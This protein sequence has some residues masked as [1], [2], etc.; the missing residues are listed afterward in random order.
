MALPFLNMQ[1][2][3]VKKKGKICSPRPWRIGQEVG[4]NLS[5]DSL[6]YT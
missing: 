4:L 6:V 2:A 5:T 3:F 1:N